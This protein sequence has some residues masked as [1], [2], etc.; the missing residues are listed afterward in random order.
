MRFW[1]ALGLLVWAGCG[2]DDVGRDA[3]V[4]DASRPDGCSGC[5]ADVS[6][7][8]VG[9]PPDVGAD[10]PDTGTPVIVA[11]GYGGLRVRST[12]L[13][14]TFTD[15][16]HTTESGGDD[17][18]LLR[19]AAFGNGRFVAL[20]WSF[21]SSEDGRTWD[22]HDNPHGQWAGAVAFGN[23]MFLASGG[24]GYCARS[25][26]GTDWA[27]CTD[28]NGD[29]GFV[30]VRSVLFH[31]GA[32]HAADQD[33]VLYRSTDGDVWEVEDASF[34]DAWA[35]IVDGAIVPRAQDAPW[36]G[37][38]FSLRGGSGVIQRSTGGGFED[39]Y[40]IPA[41]NGVFQAHRFAFAIGR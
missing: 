19:A 26:S 1:W 37:D 23:G 5:A 39:V 8:D 17:M 15:E 4:R 3:S 18:A 11:V 29:A 2:D 22:A 6:F 30:H 10:A 9:A 20:G 21:F 33:G 28:V 38:G 35:A 34:G 32:F 14:Q 31:E 40:D 27:Q 12:D 16:R 13:G 24:G 7:P 41:G 25:T 36:E